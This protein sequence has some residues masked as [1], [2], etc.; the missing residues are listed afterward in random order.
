MRF[1]FYF[2][3]LLPF[4]IQ[5]LE[6][7]SL[8]ST[9][10]VALNESFILEV[11]IQYNKGNLNDLKVSDFSQDKNFYLINQY[12]STQHSIEI[13]NGKMSRTN[14]LTINYTLQPKREGV[15]KIKPLTVKAK[16]STLR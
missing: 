11:K 12:Q 13:I 7:T 10:E 3:L 9:N 4:W 14:T 16:D 8:L 2:I 1:F 15:F 6:V 5:A